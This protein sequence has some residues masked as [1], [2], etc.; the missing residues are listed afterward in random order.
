MRRNAA[1]GGGAYL[2]SDGPVRAGRHGH[3]T[4][5]CE[6]SRIETGRRPVSPFTLPTSGLALRSGRRAGFDAGKRI[7]EV[8]DEPLEHL[9]GAGGEDAVSEKGR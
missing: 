6:K 9:P 2:T 4:E 3:G 5:A 7:A 1:G 8:P